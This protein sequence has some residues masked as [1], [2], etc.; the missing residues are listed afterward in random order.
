MAVGGIAGQTRITRLGYTAIAFG[1]WDIFYYV[2]LK[3]IYDWPKSLFDWDILFLIPLPWWGPVIAPVSIA[4]LM[5]VWGTLVTRDAVRDQVPATTSIW[6]PVSALGIALAL[7][8]FM[9][10][11]FHAVRQGVDVPGSVLPTVF[12]WP[13]FALAVT[14]MA[15]PVAH[16]AW[17]MML[18]PGR[19]ALTS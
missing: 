11:S 12:N 4:V 19:R 8:V 15:A 16:L 3:I 18:S 17:R 9:A 2:F 6:W 14:L 10:D 1:I 13:L 5:I 7:Y